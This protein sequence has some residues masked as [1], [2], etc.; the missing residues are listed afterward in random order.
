M[1]GLSNVRDKQRRVSSFIRNKF[2]ASRD[3]LKLKRRLKHST[4]FKS[5][6]L[7]MI[8][9]TKASKE[10]D[11]AERK[12]NDLSGIKRELDRVSQIQRLIDEGKHESAKRELLRDA[13]VDFRYFNRIKR[14]LETRGTSEASANKTRGEEASKK[15]VRE[16]VATRRRR[17]NFSL[18]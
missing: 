6:L 10:A 11:A 12:L 14:A 1:I 16:N 17:E 2:V 7:S 9:F 18:A 13:K 15:N 3:T 5:S 4:S 8:P